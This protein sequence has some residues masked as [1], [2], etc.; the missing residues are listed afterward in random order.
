MC[1]TACYTK[2]CKQVLKSF[3]IY[4]YEYVLH[5]FDKWRQYQ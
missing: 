1:L 3:I 2:Y 4:L 5:G